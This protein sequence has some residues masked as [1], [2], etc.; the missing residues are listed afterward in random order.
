MADLLERFLYATSWTFEKP[1]A[2][3]APLLF[4]TAFGVICAVFFA[5]IAA[6]R[7]LS[8]RHQKRNGHRFRSLLFFCGLILAV[9]ELYKQAFLYVVVFHHSYNWWYFPFQLCS[10]PMYL[11]LLLPLLPD[12]RMRTSVLTFLQ[13]F[14]IL[15]GIMALLV[16][17]GFLWEYIT[18]TCHG[19]LWHFLLIFIG[20]YIAFSQQSDSTKAGYLSALPLYGACCLI[21]TA[22]NLAVQYCLWPYSYANMFYINPCFP[23]EQVVF[24]TIALTFGTPVGLIAYLAASCIGAF[25]VH[26]FCGRITPPSSMAA[27]KDIDSR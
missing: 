10:V 1:R 19:F 27:P 26:C 16:P 12:G 11:C 17:D 5:R 20:F 8:S 24:H 4:F 25:F 14:G 7:F 2:Y 23:S 3:S 13:D 15:G 9:C 21:A 18:L 6:A 22:I